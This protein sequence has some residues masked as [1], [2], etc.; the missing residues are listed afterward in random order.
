MEE[1]WS[2]RQKGIKKRHKKDQGNICGLRN[3]Q[4][5]ICGKDKD[6]TV[7]RDGKRVRSTLNPAKKRGKERDR[8]RQKKR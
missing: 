3:V 8:K 7:W 1:R 6:K 4:K 5:K 2:A